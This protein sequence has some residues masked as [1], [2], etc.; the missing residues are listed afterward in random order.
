MLLGPLLR[1]P[2]NHCNASVVNECLMSN[3][4]NHVQQRELQQPNF[5]K[6]LLDFYFTRG[7]HKDALEM[8]Y[9]LSHNDEEEETHSNDDD[10]AFDDFLKGP[11]L[12]IQY[13]KKMTNQDL[14]LVFQFSYWVIVEETDLS[15]IH[16]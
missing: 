3:I 6:E 14:D 10:N 4:H 8:L 11:D 1:L 13:L 12:T 9:R 5:I 15:L 2:N 7:L 16:I